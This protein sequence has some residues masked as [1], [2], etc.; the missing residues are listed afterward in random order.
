ML[1]IL[2]SIITALASTVIVVIIITA[3]ALGL[4]RLLLPVAGQYR[5]EIAQQI[6]AA[7][8]RP[9]TIGALDAAWQ[10]MNP[11]LRLKDLLS[12]KQSKQ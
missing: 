12:P 1:P 9:V 5:A 8:G 11:Y 3:A 2:R 7:V 10:G 6:S 4:A